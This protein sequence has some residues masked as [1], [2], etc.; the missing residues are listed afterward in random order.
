VG[1]TF[2]I[3]FACVHE[4]DTETGSVSVPSPTLQELPHGFGTVLL[5]EDNEGVRKI[6][7]QVLQQ[8]GYTVLEAAHGEQAIQCADNHQAAIDL[9]LTDVIMPG[10]NGRE[11][12]ERLAGR[13]PAMKVLYMSGYTDDAI[14]RHGGLTD[15]TPVIE[16]PFTPDALRRK[17]Y[18]VL[19]RASAK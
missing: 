1:T 13:R 2:K 15:G 5:V 16:K 10:I 19:S 9:L 4:P 6:T 3:Y 12:A 7:R 14:L 11:L 17:V 8:A 18:D